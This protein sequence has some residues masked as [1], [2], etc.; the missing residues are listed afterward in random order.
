M[1]KGAEKDTLNYLG[2]ILQLNSSSHLKPLL[3][4]P[5]TELACAIQPNNAAPTSSFYLDFKMAKVLVCMWQQFNPA[6]SLYSVSSSKTRS[7]PEKTN[8]S[9]QGLDFFK[10]V[11]FQ[12]THLEENSALGGKCYSEG[13]FFLFNFGPLPL[14]ICLCS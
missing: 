14:I 4:L 13:R 3:W 8:L 2:L 7:R 6:G 9:R 5:G 10:P 11:V 1:W 12:T